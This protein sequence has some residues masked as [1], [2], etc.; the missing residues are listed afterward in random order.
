VYAFSSVRLVRDET[1][2][3]PLLVSLEL[4]DLCT[5]TSQLRFLP[6][7]TTS[8]LTLTGENITCTMC[9]VKALL[10]QLHEHFSQQA[11]IRD[12]SCKQTRAVATNVTVSDMR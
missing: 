8:Y 10:P 2:G 11:Y 3:H 9:I 4:G 6:A 5:C 12:T 1:K 7:N